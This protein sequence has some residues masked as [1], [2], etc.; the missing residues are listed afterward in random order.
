MV[1][2]KANPYWIGKDIYSPQSESE[3]SPFTI[4]RVIHSNRHATLSAYFGGVAVYNTALSEKEME[5]LSMIGRTAE[6]PVIKIPE[7]Q[8]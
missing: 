2:I 6:Y 5:K 4:G 1:A 8:N 3:G 7:N